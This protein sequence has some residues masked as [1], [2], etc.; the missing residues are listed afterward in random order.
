MNAYSSSSVVFSVIRNV[1]VGG[2]LAAAMICSGVIAW[3]GHERFVT[4][5]NDGHG[6]RLR[7][8]P[9]QSLSPG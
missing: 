9:R 6:E 5:V 7:H 4:I 1:C 8:Q 3:R 2:A